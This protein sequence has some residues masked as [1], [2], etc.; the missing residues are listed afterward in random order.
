MKKCLWPCISLCLYLMTSIASAETI[1]IPGMA[2]ISDGSFYCAV[3]LTSGEKGTVGP[4][5]QSCEMAYSLPVPVGRT[6][7]S[8]KVQYAD[9]VGHITVYVATNRIEPSMGVIILSSATTKIYSSSPASLTV[10]LGYSV[11]DG[12]T[13]FVHVETD[14]IIQGISATYH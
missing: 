7:D 6:L 8:V 3:D 9:G 11:W 4:A 10:P 13:Y 2:G 14:A 1:N 5:A 12:D